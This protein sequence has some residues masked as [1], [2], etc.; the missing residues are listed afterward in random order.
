MEKRC[1][2]CGARGCTVDHPIYRG[3][4]DKLRLLAIE[5]SPDGK[6]GLVTKRSECTQTYSIFNDEPRNLDTNFMSQNAMLRRGMRMLFDDEWE[7]SA[8]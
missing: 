7:D 4:H 3:K 1:T 2:V 8:G 6:G 5:P